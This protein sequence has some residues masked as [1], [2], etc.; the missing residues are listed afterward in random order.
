MDE[1][2]SAIVAE[3]QQDAGQTNRSLAH[4]LDVAPSTCLERVRL[5]HRRGVIRGYHADID[6]GALNRKVEAFVSVELRPPSRRAIEGFKS[7]MF[8]LPEVLSVY[9]VVGEQDFLVHVSVPDLDSLHSFLID[10]PT[11]RREVASFRSQII[12]DG[13]RKH[14]AAALGNPTEADN[15]G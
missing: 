4:K 7:A 13:V 1:P 6:P 10:R 3:L 8:A 5:L 15:V 2:D 12:Y 11:E 9:V 14:V